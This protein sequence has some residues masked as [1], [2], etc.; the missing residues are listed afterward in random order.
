MAVS[1]LGRQKMSSIF[2]VVNIL[3]WIYN[4]FSQPSEEYLY[5]KQDNLLSNL[6]DQVAHYYSQLH[7][8]VTYITGNFPITLAPKTW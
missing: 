1:T 8:E 5:I 6:P 3:T 2:Q 7:P 4:K